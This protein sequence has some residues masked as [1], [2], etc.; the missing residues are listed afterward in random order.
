MAGPYEI[1]SPK[2][3][4]MEYGGNKQKIAQAAQMGLIDPTSAV[5]AGMFIDKMRSAQQEEMAPQTTVAQDIMAAPQMAPQMAPTE[6]GVAAL[7]VPDDMV[8]DEYAGGGIVAFD[9]GGKV[10][11]SDVLR[12]LT[13][14]E[15]KIYQQ[16]GR[17]PARAQAMLQGTIDMPAAPTPGMGKAGTGPATI[18]MGGPDVPQTPLPEGIMYFPGTAPLIGGQAANV[19]PLSGVEQYERM[20]ARGE[21]IHRPGGINPNIPLRFPDQREAEA[22]RLLAANA[23]ASTTPSG[24]QPAPRTNAPAATSESPLS[25]FAEYQAMLRAAGIPADPFAEDRA[26][27]KKRQEE[28]AAQ[29]KEDKAMAMI[30]AG[31]SGMDARNIGE[32]VQKAGTAGFGHL[33]KSKKEARE[34]QREIDKINRD[35]RR[36]ETALKRGDVDKYMEFKDKAE[37]R[38]IQMMGV[39]AQRAAAS[40][41][42]AE[43]QYIERIMKDPEFAAA[44]AKAAQIKAEPK[45]RDAARKTWAEDVLIRKQ[46]PNFEDY[47]A[48][49][50]GTGER[51][52]ANYVGKYG[53]EPRG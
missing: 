46:Y 22:N 40:R 5:M 3:I 12:T 16:T 27:M 10:S 21:G 32:F 15:A 30:V 20:V 25:G 23:A 13:M 38:R 35:T 36:A 34:E 18:S 1:Q 37:Q 24:Q 17:L 9:K 19:R 51:P 26:D 33:A 49:I 7:P 43:I 29:S 11:L 14:D 50:S 6:A 42:P 31:L 4:A 52:S 53:L 41:S 47:Y 48:S 45:S 39:E 2:D 28:L 44:A 8:P